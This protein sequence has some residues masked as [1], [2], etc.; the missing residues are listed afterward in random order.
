MEPS[1]LN[2]SL[3]SLR[4]ICLKKIAGKDL[5]DNKELLGL[6]QTT[7]TVIREYQQQHQI[8]EMEIVLERM[9]DPVTFETR[10][11]FFE[12]YRYVY[13]IILLLIGMVTAFFSPWIGLPL[14]LLVLIVDITVRILMN[15]RNSR[16]IDALHQ[17][18]G[19][20]S[21]IEMLV[22]NNESYITAKV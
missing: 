16:I 22:R 17:I 1:H 2:R 11:F 13:E 20:C 14:L 19:G 7:R 10:P 9:P 3:L 12:A 8:P 15:R 5:I 21:S 4:S 18:A 6:F